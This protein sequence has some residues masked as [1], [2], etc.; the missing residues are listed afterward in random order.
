MALTDLLAKRLREKRLSRQQL[1]FQTRNKVLDPFGRQQA[2][3]DFCVTFTWSGGYR[4]RFSLRERREVRSR[5]SVRGTLLLRLVGHRNFVRRFGRK[6]QM[7]W[8]RRMNSRL[9]LLL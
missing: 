6:D 1:L 4:V 8:L 3:D 2:C 7:D 9:E 5:F